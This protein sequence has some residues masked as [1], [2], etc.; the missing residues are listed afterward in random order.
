MA[1][2]LAGAVIAGGLFS[3]AGKRKAS[4]R[5]RAI[6]KKNANL[7]RKF[8]SRTLSKRQDNIESEGAAVSE[9][10]D[11]YLGIGETAN[12]LLRGGLKNGEFEQLSADE[13][14]KIISKNIG[15]S[16]NRDQK[17]RLREGMRALNHNLASRGVQGSGYGQ[18]AL[19]QYGQEFAQRA[20]DKAFQKGV[21]VSQLEIQGENQRRVGLFRRLQSQQGVGLSA[22]GNY[23]QGKLAY[24]GQVN[25]VLGARYSALSNA[26]SLEVG[27]ATHAAGLEAGAYQDIGNAIQG[28]VGNYQ[29]QQNWNKYLGAANARGGSTSPNYNFNPGLDFNT[30]IP[31][32]YDMFD[33]NSRNKSGGV[34]LFN[35]NYGSG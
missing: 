27:T 1:L 26:A 21:T 15:K 28:A 35:L 12:E 33:R 16:Y 6:G 31:N 29:T 2:L 13:I 17:I 20:E 4:K 7:L 24:S 14:E 8:E 23:Q 18:R 10:Y 11:S 9:K 19:V 32:T 34:P 30:N 25:S 3:A 5:I 22:T